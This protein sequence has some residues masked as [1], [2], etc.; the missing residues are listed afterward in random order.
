MR[1]VFSNLKEINKNL[2]GKFLF[3]F[4]DCDGTL[5][6]IANTPDQA[7][8]PQ[9]TKAL[10]NSLANKSNCKIAIISG[11]ELD[12]IKKK[13]NLKNLIYS[14]NHGLQIEGPKIKQELTTSLEYRKLLQS[15]KAQLKKELFG[16]KGVIVEDK[17]LSLSL[18]FRMADLKQVSF[19][20]KIF[21]KITSI[22]SVRNKIIIKKGKMLLEIRPSIKWDKGKVVMW[23]LAKRRTFLKAEKI[24]SVYIGDDVT[25]E[26]AFKALKNKGL[27]IFVGKPGNS[28][29]KY[30]LKNPQE[31]TKFLRWVNQMCLN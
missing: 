22:H 26:D 16:V 7:V 1:Y 3:L 28:Q 18:H 29:A 2:K 9:K 6:P 17:K 31:V 13:I 23:L 25:D 12:N 14:G 20:K 10:L 11:R 8:I 15:V 30:Y 5:A 21:Y 24:V 4:L 27:T 19:I